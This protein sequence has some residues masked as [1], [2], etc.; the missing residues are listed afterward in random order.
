M[1]RSG[2]WK[3]DAQVACEITEKFVVPNR[4]GIYVYVEEMEVKQ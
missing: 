2:F 1:T 4:P 3:D